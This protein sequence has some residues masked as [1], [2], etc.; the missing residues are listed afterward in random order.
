MIY[1]P[2]SQSELVYS[3]SYINKH[4]DASKLYDG[5]GLQPLQPLY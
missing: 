2:S 5:S 1:S 4:T 3:W